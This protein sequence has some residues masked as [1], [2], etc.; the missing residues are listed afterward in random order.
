MAVNRYIAG[1][2]A[3][4]GLAKILL[5]V[6]SAHIPA[7]SAAPTS[8]HANT[9][10]NNATLSESKSTPDLGIW[11]YLGFAAA[12]V[13]SGG[14]FAGLTIALMGQ[15]GYYCVPG[16]FFLRVDFADVWYARAG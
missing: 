4:L 2:P 15:V 10:T 1:R 13:L 3:V 16:F 14:A 7:I 8:F 9:N 12:L 5:L 6:A 11:L